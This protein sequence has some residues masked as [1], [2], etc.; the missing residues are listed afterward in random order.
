[1]PSVWMSGALWGQ[2][3]PTRSDI[4]PPAQGKFH[5]LDD[6]RYEPPATGLHPQPI[7]AHTQNLMHDRS[8]WQATHR[9]RE[10]H[11]MTFDMSPQ[12]FASSALQGRMRARGEMPATP[13]LL[14]PT[15]DINGGRASEDGMPNWVA[16]EGLHS[17]WTCDNNEGRIHA[18][19]GCKRGAADAATTS[20]PSCTAQHSTAPHHTHGWGREATSGGTSGGTSL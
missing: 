4:N 10:M 1:M 2:L 18:E 16:R 12:P 8:A 5:A 9:H 15:C 6:L 19:L 3:P 17:L 7:G 11:S 20:S 14:L 13:R